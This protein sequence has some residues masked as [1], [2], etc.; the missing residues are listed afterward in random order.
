MK[1]LRYLTQA[2][3]ARRG[4]GP[5]PTRTDKPSRWPCGRGRSWVQKVASRPS[6]CQYRFRDTG[7]PRR[8]PRSQAC[9][10]ARIKLQ[11]DPASRCQAWQASLPPVAS[12]PRKEAVRISSRGRRRPVPLC[13]AESPE[14]RSMAWIVRRQ[15][16]WRRRQRFRCSPR[17]GTSP[18]KATRFHFFGTC[19][20]TIAMRPR[21][22]SS[23][24]SSHST[25]P[26]TSPTIIWN[27]T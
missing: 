19:G 22:Y 9:R 18:T 15:R 25:A 16:Q 17:Q 7:L 3:A 23:S 1:A 26:A 11:H 6:R 10:T 20:D 2:S 13:A 4:A 21:P 8:H 24:G 12:V 14:I 27:P 5:Q